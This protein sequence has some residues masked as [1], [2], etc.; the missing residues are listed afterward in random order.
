MGRGA[1]SP[2]HLIV[3]VTVA[4]CWSGSWTVGK[5]GVAT[6]PPLELSAVRFALAGLI[7]LG[8]AL[9]VRTPLGLEESASA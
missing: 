4:L 8:L 5:L 3:Y 2:A 7:M 1:R 6:I 9:A